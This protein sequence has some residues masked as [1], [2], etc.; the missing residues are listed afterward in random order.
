MMAHS[1]AFNYSVST[2][3]NPGQP[4]GATSPGAELKQGDL[5]NRI[6]N[7]L[8]DLETQ[9]QGQVFVSNVQERIQQENRRWAYTTVKTVL[10]RLVDKG[11][12]SRHKAGKKFFY[13]TQLS[14]HHAATE[15]LQKLIIQYY[16]GDVDALIRAASALPPQLPALLSTQPVAAQAPEPKSQTPTP[17]QSPWDALPALPQ[18]NIPDCLP[19]G[20]TTA[21]RAAAKGIASSVAASVAATVAQQRRQLDYA[22]RVLIGGPRR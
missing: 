18:E 4:R 9:D 15:A 1:H 20:A 16:Q 2:P 6:L 19:T 12:A 21:H 14:R 7:A 8:W 3:A 11:Q 13:K 10:D 5:E 17:E 22:D